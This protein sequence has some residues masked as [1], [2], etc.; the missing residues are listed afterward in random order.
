MTKSM[1]SLVLKI[2][3]KSEAKIYLNF[4]INPTTNAIVQVFI[5]SR[6]WN[7]CIEKVQ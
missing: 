1:T 6:Y 4:D 2:L 3:T 5:V 7:Q